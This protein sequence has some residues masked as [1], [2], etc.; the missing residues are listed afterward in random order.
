MP[1]PDA[2]ETIPVVHEE[3]SVSKQAVDAGTVQ[4]RKR[5]HERDL[6]VDEPMLHDEVDIEHVA[7]NRTVD[8]PAPPREEG[9]VLIVPV[10]EEV[11][12]VQRRW[13]LKEEIRLR[14]REVLT[15]HRERVT[16]REEQVSVQRSSATAEENA[17]GED[18]SR[19]DGQHR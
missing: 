17:D 3:A 15:R 14:R 10:Y 7:V 5:V 2:A 18:R 6:L 9:G 16:L 11:V 1:K 13:V 4:V 12:T 19:P 8:A